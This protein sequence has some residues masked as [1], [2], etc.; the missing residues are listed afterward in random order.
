[1]E[2]LLSHAYQL[3]SLISGPSKRSLFPKTLPGTDY[4]SLAFTMCQHIP[5]ARHH[6]LGAAAEDEAETPCSLS[7]ERKH[8]QFS[9]DM[10]VRVRDVAKWPKLCVHLG[11]VCGKIL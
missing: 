7:S 2:D 3:H 10:T 11:T 8:Q 4:N 1:M 5:K 9:E 6:V